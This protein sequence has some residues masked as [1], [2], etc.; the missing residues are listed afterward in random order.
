[1][2]SIAGIRIAQNFSIYISAARPS[3]LI[4][5]QNQNCRAFP[6]HKAVT[7]FVKGP[8]DCLGV[9]ITAKCHTAGK[10]RNCQ[11]IDSRLTAACNDCIRI[12][13]L[14]AVKG[15]SNCIRAGRT[16]SYNRNTRAFRT[17]PDRNCTGC[18]INNHIGDHIG[19]N[20]FT[21]QQFFIILK[22]S[23]NTANTAANV[24][25]KPLRLNLSLNITVMQSLFSCSNRI[26]DK[27]VIFTKFT[28]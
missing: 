7:V 24:N 10:A 6:Q 12:A 15:F 9:W 20:V 13:V 3:M 11:V 28:F 25:T 8:A 19:R 22:R 2:I 23:G 5:F 26:L 21:L 16:R 18:H 27:K 17:K 14:D 4:F 1:M